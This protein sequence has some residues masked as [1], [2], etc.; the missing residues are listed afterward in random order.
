M[1]RCVRNARTVKYLLINYNIINILGYLYHALQHYITEQEIGSKTTSRS[2]IRG[3]VLP[4]K[5]HHR[6][7]DAT[8]G[9]AARLKIEAISDY[10]RLLTAKKYRYYRPSIDV[11]PWG[12]D[13]TLLDPSVTALSLPSHIRGRSGIAL[14]LHL[15]PLVLPAGPNDR[16]P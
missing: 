16:H 10:Q 6:H 11:P 3:S 7:H 13:M 15:F 1:Q 5:V 2:R 4:T 14:E 8:P 12:L 9:S